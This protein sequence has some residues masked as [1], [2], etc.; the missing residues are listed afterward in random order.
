MNARLTSEE[1][2][3]GQ[4]VIY[5]QDLGERRNGSGAAP[6]RTRGAEEQMSKR[7]AISSVIGAGL[8]LTTAASADP[9]NPGERAITGG[10]SKA[11]PNAQ[12]PL[13]DGSRSSPVNPT[14]T[15]CSPL[16]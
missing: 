8:L 11:L 13:A 1:G 6:P 7:A 15:Q 2:P 12:P 3:L 4:V 9:Y 5:P 16:L 10:L 14:L